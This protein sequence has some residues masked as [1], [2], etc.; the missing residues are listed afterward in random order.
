M[1][2]SYDVGSIP[3]R[4]DYKTILMG[5]RTSQTLMPLLRKS[6]ENDSFSLFR[7]EVSSVFVEKLKAGID[8]PNY[9]QFRDMN[10][11]FF[12]L[13]NGWQ[14]TQTGYVSLGKLTA[15]FG[16]TIPEV[17]AIRQNSSLI[18]DSAS[19]DSFKL[20]ICVTG[21]YTLSSFFINRGPK[22]F[23]ELGTSISKILSA[24]IFKKKR[25]EVS[26]IFVDEPLL[27]FVNDP[28]LDHGSLG[29][30][31]L[32][33]SWERICRVASINNIESGIH[34][35]NTSDNL[36]WEVDGLDVVESHVDDPLYYSESTLSHLSKTG[37]KL[38]A[39]IAITDFDKL[40]ANRIQ[41][42]EHITNIQER[43]GEEWSKIRRKEVDPKIFLEDQE[44]MIKRL[45]RI[46]KRFKMEH[47]QYAGPECGLRSYPSYECALECLRR[48]SKAL[49]SFNA[50]LSE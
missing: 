26:M 47:V 32:L 46:I 2:K 16:A 3:L 27:G 40:I 36:F 37:K 1:I 34:L 41:D 23:D 49:D 5:A 45:K 29:R 24:S 11:M 17:D 35:H 30:R 7:D 31:S 42:I 18:A 19:V 50:E 12:E 22:L 10:E 28:L 44:T 4:I 9:P 25:G 33:D 6:S 13:I 15:R 20:K 8:V 21:P 39:S 14:K 43:I 48:I 38:K